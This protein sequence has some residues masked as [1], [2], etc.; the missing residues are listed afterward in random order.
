MHTK[1]QEIIK[2]SIDICNDFTDTVSLS[3][4]LMKHMEHMKK[5]ELVFGSLIIILQYDN[6]NVLFIIY[7]I[8]IINIYMFALNI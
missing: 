6:I 3:R 1:H 8:Y 5:I 4:F 7:Y 2:W